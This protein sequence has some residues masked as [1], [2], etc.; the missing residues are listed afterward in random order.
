MISSGVGT[1]VWMLGSGG[2]CAVLFDSN[3]LHHQLISPG[4]TNQPPIV[5]LSVS[6]G[7]R[8]PAREILR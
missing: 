1:G 2:A 7:S 6:E 8:C 3:L 4:E 5:I